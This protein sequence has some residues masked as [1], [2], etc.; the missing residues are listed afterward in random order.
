MHVYILYAHPAERSFCRSILEEFTCG[1]REAGH[2]Y[3]VGDLY[4]AGFPSELDAPQYAREVGRD[5]EAPVPA[6]VR[7]EQ[8][9]MDRAQGLAFIYPVWW[10]ECPAKLKGWFDRVWTY[11]YAY[12]YGPD[13]ERRTR[14]DIDKALVLCSAGHTAQHLEELGIAEAMRRI[15]LD[16]RLRGIGVKE[17]R[18]EIL[19]GMM[20]GDDIWREPNLRRAR[21]LG[22]WF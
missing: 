15:M 19:G 22:S 7:A 8:E 12:Y 13:E 4:S 2:T 3:E 20:P 10:S 1:L 5:P 18:M 14:I 21:E 6:D 11:G 9:K 16:D 17:T